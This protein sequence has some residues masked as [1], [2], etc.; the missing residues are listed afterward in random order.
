MRTGDFRGFLFTVCCDFDDL[1]T[2]LA[3]GIGLILLG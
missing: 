3:I 2:W 1:S